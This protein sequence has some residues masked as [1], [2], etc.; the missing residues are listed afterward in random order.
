MT[1]I[2][3]KAVSRR[4]FLKS[5]TIAAGATA[6]ALA[7]PSVVTAQSPVVLKMQ[8]SWPA[9]DVF[10][11]M[12]QQ[13]VDIVQ[14]SS[15]GRIKIDL[16]PSGAVV[17]AFQVQDAC[18][19]GAIDAAHTVPVYWYGK[20][21]G[22]SLFGTGPV[23]GGTAA[24]MLG[25][26]YQG[27][28]KDF[29]KELVQDILGLNLVGFYGMPMPA[30]PLGWFKNEVT[31]AEQLKALKYRTVGLAADLFQAMGVSVTQLP[32][33]EIVP[34]MD[35]GVIDAFE[36]NNPTSDKRFGAQD[37]AK[38]YMLGSYHQASEAFE[39][40]FNKDRFDTL[41]PDL[42]AILENSALAASTAN[43][44]LAMRQYS[45]DLKEL[46]A[47]GINI[48]RT[49]DSILQAQLAAW[50]SLIPTLEGDAFIKKVLDSQRA[51]VEQVCYYQ[52]MNA[53]N[54][55][56]AYDHYFPGKLPA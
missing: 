7:M 43:L 19:D 14:N 39:F 30:Q 6:G 26:F 9:S 38:N 21:K 24:D 35:R 16:L 44:C 41:D 52:L 54:Y 25:W 2:T 31:D 34:A 28:G 32:G 53:P 4:R 18:N 37:V 42:Q 27:G 49:P 40:M 36:F 8:S 15:G 47:A 55:R 22:A 29:Y 45:A 56:I 10:Q 33:G 46:G 17:G 20:H 23:F 1:E 11:E 13:Y 3:E 48:K 5:G 51:W 12:A 50:D